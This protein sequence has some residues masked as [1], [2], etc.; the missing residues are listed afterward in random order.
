MKTIIFLFLFSFS[1]ISSV[2]AMTGQQWLSEIESNNFAEKGHSLGYLQGLRDMYSS[3]RND[4]FEF[5]RI[6]YSVCFPP[7]MTLGQIKKL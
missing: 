4:L 1:T 3:I 7:N 5:K 2:H 6:K